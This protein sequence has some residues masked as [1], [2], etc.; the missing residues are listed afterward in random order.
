MANPP[1][2]D[3]LSSELE[4]RLDELFRE[5]GPAP[6][7]TTAEKAQQ[8]VERPGPAAPV[9]RKAKESPLAELKKI[10]LSI[11]WEITPEALDSFL[12]QVR[13]LN[14]AYQRDKVISVFLQILGSLGHYIKSSR[15]QVHPSTFNVLNSVFTRLDEVVSTP[16]MPEAA[17]RK[18]L[19]AEMN[20]YQDLRAKIMRRQA[21]APAVKPARPESAAEEA[22]APAS[23]VVTPEMLALAVAELKELI[24][25]EIDSLRR[26]LRSGARRE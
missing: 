21:A 17:R 22:E 1:K 26:L 18:L 13:L 5:N 2:L 20:A 14:E 24:R 23:R 16:K 25:T 3:K 8:R 10:V 19:Q 15:S 11:D 4:N 12:D 9:T 7:A 6:T